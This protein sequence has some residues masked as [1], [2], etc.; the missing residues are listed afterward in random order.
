MLLKMTERPAVAWTR[1]LEQGGVNPDKVPGLEPCLDL[2]TQM[3][4]FS[5][6]HRISATDAL[7][8]PYFQD[9]HDPASEIECPEL[10]SFVTEDLPEQEV[11]DMIRDESFIR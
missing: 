3:I 9:Y 6:D 10:F 11:Y 7:A 5:P 4:R 2:I 8:H 1:V